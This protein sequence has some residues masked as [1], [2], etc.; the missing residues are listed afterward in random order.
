MTSFEAIVEQKIRNNRGLYE[1]MV[2]MMKRTKKDISTKI[3][4][5]NNQKDAREML[6]RI[7]NMVVDFEFIENLQRE[8]EGLKKECS[9]L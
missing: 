5:V 7:N 9:S 1:S 4:Q 3:L 6:I 8:Y 2:D